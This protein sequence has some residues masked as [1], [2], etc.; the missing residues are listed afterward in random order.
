MRFI[1]IALL[2]LG[3]LSNIQAQKISENRALSLEQF[4]TKYDIEAGDYIGPLYKSI[5]FPAE[6]RKRGDGIIVELN[7][8]NLENSI[9]QFEY[10]EETPQ[11]VK[12]EIEKAFLVANKYLPESTVNTTVNLSIHFKVEGDQKK[13]I[14]P[15]RQADIVVV[16]YPKISCGLDTKP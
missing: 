11:V 7:V 16:A 10:F 13:A 3:I 15:L 14:T 1:I 2:L 12:D 6:L 8:L 9:T 5:R 4:M